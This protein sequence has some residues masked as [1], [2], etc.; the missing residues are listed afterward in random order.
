MAKERIAYIDVAK[1]L[2]IWLMVIGHLDISEQIRVYIYSFH[3]PLFFIVSGMFFK[4]DRSFIMNLNSSLRSVLWP[5]LSFSVINL[6]ICWISPY[7]H[8]E[9]Y[10]DLHGIEVFYAAVK[11]IFIGTDYITPNSFMPLG[12]LWFLVSLFTI[13]VLTSAISALVRN[14]K[15][16][17]FIALFIPIVLF[18]VIRTNIPFSVRSSMMAI[19]F[20]CIGYIMRNMDI[21]NLPYKGYLFII[22]ALF[23]IFVIPLNG[24]CSID[25]CIYGKSLLLFYINAVIS[26]LMVLIACSY[27]VGK[28]IS[29]FIELIGQHT[30]T[31]LGVHTFPM[32]VMKVAGV[33]L[34]GSAVL[35]SL[36]FILLVSTIVIIVSY[37]MGQI[38]SKYIPYILRI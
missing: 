22:L 4:R 31:I 32:I 15:L 1:G 9:L 27:I 38:I 34:W 13:Q 21:P 2:A 23:F 10:Y 17:L 24:F 11:G 14:N 33:S 26:T 29:R 6:S 30:L 20:Y 8:P 35:S 5:Y 28:R 3:M 36:S 16:F 7:L 19:P 37:I 25:E 12:A 18:L